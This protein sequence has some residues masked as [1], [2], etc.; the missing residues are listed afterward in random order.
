[1]SVAATQNKSNTTAIL[2]AV[3][4]VVCIA[5]FLAFRGSDIGQLPDL[6]ASLIRGRL[7]GSAVFTSL[8]GFVVSAAICLA[9][10]G[11]GGAI[12]RLLFSDWRSNILLA[13]GLR[14]AIGAGVWSL[15]WFLL[16]V[17]GLYS[18]TAAVVSVAVGGGCA[19]FARPLI[20]KTSERFSTAERLIA[21]CI[22]LP[23]VLALIAA[24]AP[25]I[26]KDALLY[27][28]A[29][30]KAYVWQGVNWF[31]EG[32]IAS[33]IALGTEMHT[34]WAMLLGNIVSPRAGEA[35]AGATTFFFFAILL[36]VVFGWSRELG[37]S[38]VLSLIATLTVATIPT[39]Y[40]VASSGYIDLSLALYV[41]LAGY[42]L[43]RWWTDQNWRW[44]LLVAIFLGAALSVKL[45]TVF[46]FAAVVLIVL[47]RARASTSAGK[48]AGL[49]FASLFLAAAIASPWYIRTWMATGSPVFPFYM[50]I[51][52][53][54]ADGWDVARSNLFQAMNAQYGG[55][56]T[57]KLNYL[58]A[59][60]RVSV[61]AQPEQ[62]ANYDGV[63]GPAFLIGLPLLVYALWKPGLAVE[64][65]IM[66][67]V[68]AVMYLFWLF[69]S[70][71]LRYLLP[72]VPM[73]AIAIAA[74]TEK[75][76]GRVARVAQVSL[77][78]ASVCGLLT[79]AAWFSQKAPLGVVLGGESRDEYL[80]RNLDYYPY[81]Q[82]I[83][84]SA[85]PDAKV[86]LINMRRDTYYID[87]PVVSDYLFEDWTLR[88][89]LWEARSTQELKADAASLGV[90]YIMTRH[91]FLF[92]YGRSTLV[93]DSRP[94]SENEA[95]L[96]MARE[97]IL[98]PA[99]TVKADAKFSLVKLY[100]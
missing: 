9:W 16:G 53:G 69:T 78:A 81:Y 35:A 91:D 75:I 90:Q 54:Q 56:D 10:Y 68:A 92:D 19:L 83:N 8:A 3:F 100:Q 77:V 6:L 88:K 58:T 45:T 2:F 61:T 86:W 97:L 39:A 32:N 71:Q 55:V 26:A 40:H 33:Y 37:V 24:V 43:T 80:A 99:R 46:A 87:R 79:I 41:T 12:V 4:A 51:W 59:P 27:H 72:I 11:T 49:G 82:E 63:L 5:A 44:T 98:D 50:S 94:R 70:E 52:P 60:V 62:A 20:R 7:L 17:C 25:P 28:F 21:A 14:T 67:G 93:D 96:A 18:S 13:I 73:L 57:T 65:K 47:I 1:M 85:P 84:E 42:A 38:R 48:V 74:A 36:S 31:I 15:V 22:A 34:T 30:P 76:G 23:L 66:A 95:K 29:L 89:M 64:I